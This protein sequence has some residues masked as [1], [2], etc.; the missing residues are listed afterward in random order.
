M[1]NIRMIVAIMMLI[2]AR[3]VTGYSQEESEVRDNEIFAGTVTSMDWVGSV[4]AVNDTAFSVSG[5]TKFFK[6]VEKIDFTDINVKDQVTVIYRKDPSSGAPQAIRVTV[7][8]SGDFP[9]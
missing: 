1:R 8:Y 7:S 6:G 3:T 2:A 9:V 4:L 5:D